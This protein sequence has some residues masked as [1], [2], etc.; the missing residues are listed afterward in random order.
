MVPTETGEG[1]MHIIRFIAILLSITCLNSPI[2][3]QALGTQLQA[4]LG[5]ARVFNGGGISFA[6]AVEHPISAPVSRLQH[7]LGG[8]LWYAHTSIASAP[9]DPEG[10]HIVGLGLR[11]QVGIGTCCRSLGLFFALPVQLLRSSIPDRDDLVASSLA[12]HGIPESPSERPAEDRI[13]SAWGWGAGLE[14]G[15][16]VGLAN[17]LSAQTSVQ[18]LYQNIYESSRRNGAWSWHSGLTYQFAAP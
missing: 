11:Y 8:S 10:R 12:A 4:G 6:A 13:G 3:A 7:A 5:Y 1:D 9:D 17:Q 16:R 15:V 14:V 2:Q 18:A